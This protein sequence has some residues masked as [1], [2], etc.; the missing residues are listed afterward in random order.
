MKKRYLLILIAITP[1]LLMLV[2]GMV[3]AQAP[4][5]VPSGTG[6]TYQGQ[7]KDSGV[8]YTGS[9]DFLFG[10][11]DS[12]TGG[13]QASYNLAL[14]NVSV[15][16][17]SF[18]VLLDW[19]LAA[20]QGE[21]RWIDISVSCP[22]GIGELVQLS[23][24]QPVT[25]TPYALYALSAD[26]L[27]MQ[28]RVTG[29]CEEGFAI[30]VVNY[31]GSVTCEPSGG[32]AWQLTGNAGTTPGTN[33]LGTS[34]DVALELKV[35]GQRA[36]RLEPDDTSPNLI[37]GYP[38]NQITSGVYGA[39]IG[40]G[41]DSF[42]PNSVTDAFSTVGGG[43]GNQAGDATG[44]ITSSLYA[45]VGGGFSNIANGEGATVSGGYSNWAGGG[46]TV[47]G[48][49]ENLATGGGG[50]IGGGSENMALGSN[51]AICGGWQ[52][53]APGYVSFIGSGY[54][55]NAI[56]AWTTVGGGVGNTANNFHA[57]IGGGM[58][59]MA[60]GAESTIAGGD[61]NEASNDSAFVGGGRSNTASGIEST[62]S[63]GGDNS[64]FGNN[65]TVGGGNT[66]QATQPNATVAGGYSNDANAEYTTI[67]GGWN[68]TTN[69]TADTVS[70]GKDNTA[71]SDYS[72]VGGG[73]GNWAGGTQATVG[74]GFS[75]QATAESATIAGGYNNEANAINATV[76]GGWNN[77]ASNNSAT[78]PGGS[79]NVASGG[80]SFAAGGQCVASGLASTVGGGG[81]NIASGINATVP[82]GNHNTAQGN[83]SFAAGNNAKA[84]NKGCFVWGDSTASDVWCTTDNTWVVRS[85]GGVYFYTD[86][87]YGMGSYL[88][89]GGSS[90]NSVSDRATKEN[91]SQVDGQAILEMLAS[92]PVQEYNLKTQ[93]DSIRHVGLVAQDF[94][95]F[96]YGES[97]KAIN[98]EDADGVAM[99]AIQ[100]LY[101]ENQELKAQVTDLEARLEALEATVG[102]GNTRQSGNPVSLLW[103]F[104][105]G[106][107]FVGGGALT[108]FKLRN[109]SVR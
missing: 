95:K 98:M 99:A 34:D 17:G 48:G 107:V 27:V 3:T 100:G 103:L 45:T 30:R 89:P 54:G 56:E 101:A 13:T 47:A 37:G 26:P 81:Y 85:S 49:Y 92:L 97:D 108:G 19:G 2:T 106:M 62:V 23:P 90:W 32:N 41:G 78:V 18:S 72:F 91:F 104:A 84:L 43:Q 63:G 4:E 70:G 10:L 8:P 80:Y 50:F 11:W 86:P 57:T 21:A 67:G 24:R 74:G 105:G 53:Y 38:G 51:A 20:F 58:N 75:N 7:L 87:S 65:A 14:P 46:D 36:L 15:V 64:A 93:D 73:N 60:S 31:D 71:S 6:I 39:V 109:G 79:E 69:N 52:N 5:G 83:Y 12:P 35:N 82:G 102:D 16:D 28:K 22:A 42:Y 9:C 61:T 29:V 40:G 44:T 96:G 68:N 55:N 1:V 77:L 59:N 94:A 88:S 25:P 76:G 66:N 33:Y